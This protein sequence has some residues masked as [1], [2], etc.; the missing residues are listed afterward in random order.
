MDSANQ[1]SR[2]AFLRRS[3]GLVTASTVLGLSGV[4]AGAAETAAK[5]ERSDRQITTLADSHYYLSD[6]RIE[7]GFER[8]GDVVVGTRTGIRTLEIQNGRIKALHGADAALDAALP[9]YR[10]QGKLLAQGRLR[11]MQTL[12]RLGEA[13]RFDDCN[14]SSQKA[15]VEHLASLW[16]ITPLI[17][18]AN[19]HHLNI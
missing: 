6:V 7:E 10:A 4:Q 2:R 5:A 19:N 13:S 16:R 12:G 1:Q 14:E 9:R 3:G 11:H 17:H 15:W 8:E 18:K